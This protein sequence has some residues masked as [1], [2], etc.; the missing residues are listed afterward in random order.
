MRFLG[1]AKLFWH[2]RG[3]AGREE[4]NLPAWRMEHFGIATVEAMMA[5][6]VPLVPASGGQ[7]EIVEDRRSGF[8]CR[9]TD[10]LVEHSVELAKDEEL[11]ERMSR[12]AAERSLSFRSE[13]FDRRFREVVREALSTRA[14]VALG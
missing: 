8:L 10:E 5:G 11:R 12:M 6:C 4:E 1:E 13:V 9:D 2:S 3:L 7:T 14:R